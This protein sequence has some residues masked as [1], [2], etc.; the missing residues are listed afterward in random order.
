MEKYVATIKNLSF[1]YYGAAG[2]AL[3]GI[4]LQLRPGEFLILTGPSGCGKSTLALCLTGFIPHGYTGLMEGTVEVKGLDTRENTPGRLAGLV[5]L[6]QQ[7][8]EMQLCTL[9]VMDE[10]AFGPENLGLDPAEVTARVRWALAAVGASDLA[11]RDLYSLSGGE[12]Q[13]VAIASVLA[14]RPSLLILDE[15]TANLDPRCTAEVLAVMEKLRRDEDI[16]VIVIEHRL[17]RLLPLA[18]RALYMERGRI[19]R[20]FR[21]EELSVQAAQYRPFYRKID[22]AGK[23]RVNTPAP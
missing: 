18:D 8:P 5:G 10:V 3:E 11:E 17:E 4:N 1:T 2:P 19:V 16:T 21:G 23:P 15:P 6:V 9:R 20:E 14:M 13:K 22:R 7:D 12:K